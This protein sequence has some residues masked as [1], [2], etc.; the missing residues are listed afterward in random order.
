[1]N[2]LVSVI[3]PTCKRPH[4]LSRA[5]DSVLGQTYPYVEVVVVDDNAPDTPERA[6]TTDVMRQYHDNP[7]VTYVLNDHPMGGGPARNHGIE[8]A[9]RGE[10]EVTPPTFRP[11]DESL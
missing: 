6:Q 1:M 4:F 3:I 10:A 7:R 9:S 11:P 8:Q 5:V 2:E